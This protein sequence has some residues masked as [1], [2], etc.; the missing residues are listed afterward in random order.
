MKPKDKYEEVTKS[1]STSLKDLEKSFK[2]FS[3]LTWLVVLIALIM[4]LCN[5][6]LTLE[7]E[8]LKKEKTEII[9]SLTIPYD[10]L[11]EDR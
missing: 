9:E 6:K 10:V 8:A 3:I 7:N 1:E 11:K 5:L 4:C 2:V